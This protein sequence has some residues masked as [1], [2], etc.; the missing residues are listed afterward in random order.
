MDEKESRVWKD[1]AKV[2]YLGCDFAMR[3]MMFLVIALYFELQGI[4][5]WLMGL[6]WLFYALYHET[7]R[8]LG[9][10]ALRQAFKRKK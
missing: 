4:G 3:L 7:K 6:F 1:V 2:V 5:F 9:L 8:Y 10:D